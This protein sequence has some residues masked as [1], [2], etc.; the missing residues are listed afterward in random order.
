MAEVTTVGHIVYDIR[1]YV[2]EFPQPDKTA[3]MQ[4]A[5]Q[6][7]G[8]GSAANVAANLRTLGH[9][10]AFIGNVG[11]DRHGKFLLHELHS[12]GVDMRGVN[13]VDGA[14]GVAIIFVN[15]R[16]EV[17][18]AEMIGVNEPLRGIDEDI[19]RS[20]LALHMTSTDAAALS[21]ASSIAR[22]AGLLITF[23]PGRS[24]S[25]LGATKLSAALKNS[26]Y[27]VVNRRELGFISGKNLSH[28]SSEASVRMAAKE[29]ARKFDLTCIIKAG[30]KPVIV[31]GRESFRSEPF[32]GKVVDTIGAGD[33]FCAGFL[34]ALLEEKS[35][36][37]SVQF[38]NAAALAKAMRQGARLGMSRFEIEKKFGV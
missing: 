13:L 23:D 32:S 14:T 27:L 24:A 22:R 16:A 31:E 36:E 21:K 8:G 6:S 17:E 4:G 30:A 29:L 7:S 1:C 12:A 19:I 25:R 3:F 2:D 18:V 10:S 20:S 33:A 5:I 28:D 38:A 11:T 37:K 35:L 15:R 26:D 9:A 34:A